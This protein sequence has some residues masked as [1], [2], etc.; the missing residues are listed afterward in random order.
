[1]KKLGFLVLILGAMGLALSGC[2]KKYNSVPLHSVKY[3]EKH[4]KEIE[5]IRNLCH[6]TQNKLPISL[7]AV[8]D[9]EKSNLRKDCNNAD[10]A[11]ANLEGNY[12]NQEAK[13]IRLP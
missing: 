11:L 1:M 3:Y 10:A 8:Q 2:A 7:K 13:Q 9:Y 6:E 4:P 12:I 5:V